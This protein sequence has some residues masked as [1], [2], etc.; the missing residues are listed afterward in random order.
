[1]EPEPYLPDRVKT[2]EEISGLFVSCFRTHEKVNEFTFYG[3]DNKPIKSCC[4]Y[5]K[6]KLFAEGVRF[7]RQ[8][9]LSIV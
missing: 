8:H 1:M 5:A 2:L 4:T 9:A 6:A 3:R 7:G